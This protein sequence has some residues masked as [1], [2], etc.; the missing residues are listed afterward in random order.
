MSID[1]C[2]NPLN[3]YL[4]A[5][6]SAS[7]LSIDTYEHQ[8]LYQFLGLIQKSMLID[9]NWNKSP[10]KPL[11][12]SPSQ[13]RNFFLVN[14]DIGTN[15]RWIDTKSVSVF[16]SVLNS[17]SKASQ[18]QSIWKSIQDLYQSSKSIPM[19]INFCINPLNRYLWASISVSISR[20]DT[21]IDADRY[22]LE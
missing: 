6:I 22:Q 17:V 3:R 12:F 19:S 16:I 7:I 21:E 1:F 9:I 11:P 13:S 5:S 18:F 14:G 8:F 10:V 15:Y 20:I 4:W 2:I